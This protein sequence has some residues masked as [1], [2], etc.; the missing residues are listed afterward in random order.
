MTNVEMMDWTYWDIENDDKHHVYKTIYKAPKTFWKPIRLQYNRLK[1]EQGRQT[2]NLFIGDLKEDL[3]SLKFN[4]ASDDE[5]IRDQASAAAKHCSRVILKS[6]KTKKVE[7]RLIE[8]ANIY[9]IQAPKGKT[10]KGRFSRFRCQK[11]WRRQ[12]RVVQGRLLEKIALKLNIIHKFNNTYASDY[13]VMRRAG[14]KTRN[15]LI[16]EALEAVNEQGDAYTLQEL[17]DL[18][19]SNPVNRRN[20]L[21]ARI[22]GSEKIADDSGDIGL[23]LTLTTPSRMHSVLSQSAKPNPKYN[24]TTPKDAQNYL[25]KV[26][27]RTRSNLKRSDINFYG[28]RVVEPHHDSTPHWHLLL[29]VSPKNKLKLLETFR[30]Y[31]L[32]TDGNEKGAQ[33]HR[34][35]VEEIDKSKGTAISYVAKYISKNIDGY[36]IEEDLYGLDAKN[37]AQRIESWASLWG[38]RQ[39]QFFGTPPVTIWR[40]LRRIKKSDNPNIIAAVQAADE[41]DW[42][43][44]VMIMGGPCAEKKSYPINIMRLW[45]DKLNTYDEPMGFTIIGI[46]FKD[47]YEISRIHVWEIREINNSGERISPPWSSVNNC[48]V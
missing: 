39:F 28:I 35:K 48:T 14:Q 20:E 11:W 37:S 32:E 27:A 26:W 15:R 30:R 12:F 17:S 42:A 22:A 29:F 40:E 13:C 2:A 5:A 41:G 16:L 9:G 18:S 1:K 8:Y 47:G 19:T 34:F 36:G 44:F 7:A 31:A 21:M 46:E 6:K 33:K 45:S 43:T 24:E 4:L 38:I 10:R 3:S 25:N 23:F